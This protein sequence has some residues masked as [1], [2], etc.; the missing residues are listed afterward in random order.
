MADINRR[1][2]GTCCKLLADYTASLLTSQIFTLK[3]QKPQISLFFPLDYVKKAV[4]DKGKL[5]H[6]QDVWGN[7]GADPS[8]LAL[9]VREVFN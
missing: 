6:H 1:F 8:T 7:G 3:T 5:K 2:E 9:R 4:Y